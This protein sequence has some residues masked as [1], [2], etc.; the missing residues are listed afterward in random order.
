M[1]DWLDRV[2]RVLVFSAHADDCEFFAGGTVAKLAKNGAEITEII[3]TDNGRGSFELATTQLV[4]E[5]RDVE[6]RA[7][8]KIIG[9]KAVHFLGYPDGFLDDT[10]K[11]ELRRIFMEWV[12]RVQPDLVMSFD[13]F[14]P[15]E[16]HPDHRHVAA[17]AVEAAGFAHLP[18]YHPEQVEAGL[19]P[20]QTPYFLWFAKNDNLCN[21]AVDIGATIDTKVQAI[22]AHTSQMRMTMQDFVGALTATGRHTELIPLLDKDNFE[23][24]TD[25][26]IKTWAGKVGAAHDCEYAE[27]FRAEMAGEL[28]EQGA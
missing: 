13:L 27:A 23:P 28:F 20:H 26:L 5:S 22:C 17:A 19:A 3:A 11:N 15:F 25:M 16:T 24:A 14:A 12:R 6:A 18:L 10:P 2:K 7:A 4:S 1:L 8:A 9:K 21:E